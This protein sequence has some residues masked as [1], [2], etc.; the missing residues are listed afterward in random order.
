M[1]GVRDHLCESAFVVV[2]ASP[3]SVNTRRVPAGH[4]RQTRAMAGE[5]SS[6]VSDPAVEDLVKK[7]LTERQ[8]RN[9]S[10]LTIRNYKSDLGAFLDAL[11]AG[12][13][14]ALEA[15]RPDLRRYLASLAS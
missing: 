9:L 5:E 11:A 2:G 1:P 15:S 13:T 12:K 3:K 8:G 14:L 10:A 4:E 7:F 6:V